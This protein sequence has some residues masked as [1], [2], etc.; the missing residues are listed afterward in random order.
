MISIY[1]E[2]GNFL[3]FPFIY[4]LF[5]PFQKIPFISFALFF[6]VVVISGLR[7]FAMTT[8][9][10]VMMQ[11]LQ[12]LGQSLTWRVGPGGLGWPSVLENSPPFH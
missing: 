6:I 9:V 12:F 3:I 5:S 10:A 7:D 8:D 11:I 4:F 1:F 2:Q